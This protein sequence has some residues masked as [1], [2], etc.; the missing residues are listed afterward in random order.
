M[1]PLRSMLHRMSSI[2]LTAALAAFIGAGETSAEDKKPE[3]RS[4][5]ITGTGKISA[6]PD[7]AEILVGVLTQAP[8]AISALDANNEAVNRLS[9]ILKDRGIAEKDIQTADIQVLPQ[10]SQ[11]PRRGLA[12]G[13]QVEEELIPRIVGYRVEN[14]V[15]ITAR[16]IDKLGSLLD[17]L[18]QAGANHLRG[19]TFRVDQAEKLLDEARKRAMS[20]AK[21]KAELIAGEATL[22]VGLPL[23]IEVDGGPFRPTPRMYAG[24]AP[25]MAAPAPSMPVSPGEQELSVTVSVVYELK[26]AK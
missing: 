23:K 16:Q 19:I 13:E 9:Q 7:I 15:R 25:M 14:S 3:P 5:S 10:Y 18:V 11:P 6:R 12:P 26:E 2:T 20:D 17:A 24:A 1:S 22:V 21:H 8:T 4:L